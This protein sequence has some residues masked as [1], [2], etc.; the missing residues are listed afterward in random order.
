MGPWAGERERGDTLRTG[1][2]LSRLL[3]AVE[4]ICEEINTDKILS[5]IGTMKLRLDTTRLPCL[6]T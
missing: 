2:I 5:G 1:E 4:A 3:R 6:I